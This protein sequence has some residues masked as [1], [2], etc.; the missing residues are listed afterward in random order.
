M[1][2]VFVDTS[3]FVALANKRD[4]NHASA[5]RCL[6]SLSRSPRPLIT[7]TDIAD[8]VVTLIRMRIGHRI[9]VEV[10][11]AIFESRWCRLLEI[12]SALRER[13][14]TLFRRYDDQTFS[15]TD[16]T[17]FAVMQSLGIED[18]FTFDRKDFAAA[19]FVPVPRV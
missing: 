10:G 9:A 3:A 11:E 15:L 18:A 13:A 6:R 14:W 19:G 8:E 5:R 4:R 1:K 2:P 17:S 7:S 12:D 16:C